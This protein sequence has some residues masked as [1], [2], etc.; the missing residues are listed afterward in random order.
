MGWLIAAAI[1]ALL[2]F[3]KVSVRVNASNDVSL[4]LGI[5][6]FKKKLYPTKDDKIRLSD[7]KIKKFRKNKQ[8][9]NKSKKKKSDKK[10]K[11][12]S[13]EKK[14]DT[15]KTDEKPKR[16]IMGFIESLTEVARVL[17]S[18]FGRHLRINVK[19][20]YITVATPDAASTAVLFGAV[21]GA[22][23]CFLELF[24]NTLHVTFPKSKDL[25]VVTDFTSEKI[26]ADIDITF[27]FRLWQLFD[28]LIRSAWTYLK[29]KE[30]N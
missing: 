4:T 12:E 24:D 26:T 30:K 10:S 6:L 29:H 22:V 8:K 1:I 25:Q 27:S 20:L 19:R 28:I 21:C 16:D 7:Y 17:F 14:G 3:H 2:L 11:K 23:Q 13:P 5:G 15:Q 18:R 9:D